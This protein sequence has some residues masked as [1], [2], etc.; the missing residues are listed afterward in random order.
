MALTFAERY[1]PWALVTGASSGIGAAYAHA[2]AERGLNL[3]VTARRLRLLESLAGELKHRYGVSVQA[4]GLDL[5]NPEF[6]RPLLE[7][8]AG[9]DIGLVVS[10]AGFG[11]KGEHHRQTPERLSA[12]LA[13]NCHAP[14][15][16][17]HAFAPRLIARGHGGLMLTGS[18]EGFLG[19]PYSSAYAATKAFV[20]VL[21]EGLWGELGHHGVDVMVLSPGATDTDAPTLQG[22][23]KGKIPGPMMAPAVVVEQALARLGR[24]APVFIPGFV[25]RLM[26]HAL[27]LLPR[28]L[29][30]RLTGKGIRDTLALPEP[31]SLP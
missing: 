22:I 6:L 8:C 13:V 23:D 21:G 20:H 17:A 31:G 26:M 15:V 9:K 27:R 5:A 25:N 24:R 4:I 11:L 1:G 3:V 2:L 12:M 14:L 28:R 7:A 29:G 10:N 18:I 19:F 30:L 16:L